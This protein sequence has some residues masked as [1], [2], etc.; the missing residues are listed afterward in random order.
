MIGDNI[1]KGL[2]RKRCDDTPSAP[3]NTEASKMKI[4]I[5]LIGWDNG[6]IERKVAKEALLAAFEMLGDDDHAGIFRDQY[7]VVLKDDP[8]QIILEVEQRE[9]CAPRVRRDD[10]PSR[11]YCESHAPDDTAE[12]DLVCYVWRDRTWKEVKWIG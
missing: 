11:Q 12:D 5:D 8:G 2:N 1:I 6:G 9:V 7:G 10:K 3:T 4:E